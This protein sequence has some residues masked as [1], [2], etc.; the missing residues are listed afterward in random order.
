MSFFKFHLFLYNV[1]VLRT[2][3]LVF[4]FCFTGFREEGYNRCLL[5]S[6]IIKFSNS[7]IYWRN[8]GPIY[9]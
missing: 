6:K 7:T 3:Y 1:L 8:V 4:Y 5:A 9:S 2:R